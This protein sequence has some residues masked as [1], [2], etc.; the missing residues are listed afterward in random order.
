M[1]KDLIILLKYFLQSKDINEI[2]NYFAN[3][4]CDEFSNKN[5]EVLNYLTEEFYDIDIMIHEDKDVKERIKKVITTAIEMLE[6]KK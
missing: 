2:N 1:E 5:P 4:F 3:D 6:E